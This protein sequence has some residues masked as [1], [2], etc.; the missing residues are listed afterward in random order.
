MNTITFTVPGVPRGKG[1]P[2]AARR[3]AHIAMDTDD[4]TAAY[5]NLVRLAYIQAGGGMLGGAIEL[6]VI[7]YMPVPESWSK[8]K[9][10]AAYGAPHLGKP[11]AS[12]IQKAVE[13]GLNGVAYADDSAIWMTT[14][15]K[16]YCNSTQAACVVV[17][18]RGCAVE[19]VGTL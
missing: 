19:G 6:G 16:V 8:T 5:E 18:L 12:N 17:T 1:R 11:D 4:K 13:D 3:G 2:R 10:R 9:K 14:T 7:A 15:Q